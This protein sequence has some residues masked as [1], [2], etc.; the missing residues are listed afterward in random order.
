MT[1]EESVV[2]TRI[3]DC[4]VIAVPED[5]ADDRLRQVESVAQRCASSVALRAMVFDLSALKFADAAEFGALT[6][7]AEAIAILGVT[8]IL[9]GLNPGIIIHLVDCGVEVRQIQ[10]FLDLGDALQALGLTVDERQA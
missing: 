3:A 7:L 4:V 1:A 6:S 5:L 9:V 2:A 8:P 10:A